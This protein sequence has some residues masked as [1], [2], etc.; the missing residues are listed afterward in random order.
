MYIVCDDYKAIPSSLLVSL[1][2]E[3]HIF[4]LF[5][6]Q[7]CQNQSVV[8]YYFYFMSRIMCS[9]IQN[10]SYQWC[11]SLFTSLNHLKGNLTMS[12]LCSLGESN[13]GKSLKRNKSTPYLHLF[14]YAIVFLF[15]C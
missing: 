1:V 7:I 6:I 13:R 10:S 4:L 12:T 5:L 3:N 14:S 9:F 11:C 2:Q 8:S 15:V